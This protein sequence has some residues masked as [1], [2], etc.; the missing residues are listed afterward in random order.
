MTKTK[1]PCSVAVYC[2]ISR[3]PTGMALG[4]ERQ[5]D[6]CRKLAEKLG[7][8]IHDVLI[9][10]D[11]SAFSGKKRPAYDKLLAGLEDGTYD[12][13][14]AW[15]TDRLY[16]RTKDLGVLIDL[17]GTDKIRVPVATVTA[18]AI[19]LTSAS[20]RFS[21]KNLANAAEFESDLKSERIRAQREQ[22]AATGAWPGGRLPYGFERD[23][24]T[25]HPVE[26]PAL[27]QAVAEILAGASTNSIA[28]RLGISKQRL[29]YILTAPRYVGQRTFR[30]ETIGKAAWEPIID[31][32]SWERLQA[33][34]QDPARRKNQPGS[35]RYLLTGLLYAPDGRKLFARPNLRPGKRSIRRYMCETPNSVSINSEEVENFVVAALCGKEVT[36]DEPLSDD[37]EAVQVAAD[38]VAVELEAEELLA[39]RKAEAISLHEYMEMRKPLYARLEALREALPLAGQAPRRDDDF[40]LL[41][42]PSRRE[43]WDLSTFEQQR[44]LLFKFVKRVDIGPADPGRSRRTTDT[45]RITIDWC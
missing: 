23:G 33:I 42:P 28:I 9:D 24:V 45:S 36:D 16:R 4:V 14:L 20:G 30:G 39:L 27:R 34:M 13:V 2:R 19:D 31:P 12:G 38:I 37:G 17:I 18:G 5:E 11:I 41:D 35:R 6:A 25:H 32:E 7:W 22:V 3:D 26:A 43:R 21:A 8:E 29:R 44:A 40:W 15:A 1:T 10:N